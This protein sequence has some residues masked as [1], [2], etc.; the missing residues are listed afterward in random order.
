MKTQFSMRLTS[1]LKSILVACCSKASSTAQGHGFLR[2]RCSITPYFWG[3]ANFTAT[4]F[5]SVAA[6]GDV[7]YHP[8]YSVPRRESQTWQKTAP[9][10]GI[11][12]WIADTLMRLRALFSK[13]TSPTGS[14]SV[15]SIRQI[16]YWQ[17]Y[18]GG[19][20]TTVE[21]WHSGA[22][23]SL[24]FAFSVRT[25]VYAAPDVDATLAA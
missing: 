6:F 11:S 21:V 4:Q 18:G 25:C 13:G 16:R 7:K 3:T 14:L 2:R 9:S 8:R 19:V 22:F 1:T 17:S 24:F 23:W 10:H 20:L 12:I 15:R 5:V